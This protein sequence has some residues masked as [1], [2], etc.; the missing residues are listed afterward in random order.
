MK[1]QYSLALW[2]WAALWLMHIW[3]IKHIEEKWIIVNEVSWTSMWAIIAWLYAMWFD[4]NFMYNF[5]NQINFLKLIDFDLKNWLLKWDKIFKKLYEVFWD[6]LIEKQKIKLVIVSTNI[7]T[8]EK[9]VFKKWKIIDAVIASI[10]LPGI[11]KPYKIDNKLLID[12]WIMSNLP[13]EVLDWKNVIAVS[14]IK[15]IV[16]QLQTKRNILWFDVNVWFFNLNYQ[17]IQRSLLF[18]M[19]NNEEVSIKTLWK[20]VILI[21]PDSWKLEF[22]NFNKIDELFNLGYKEAVLV[23]N[24][25]K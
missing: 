15:N 16:W 14:V 17:V 13:I 22:H 18:M 2:W 5:A 25:L 10:S 1:K 11:F 4:S 6:E 21:K 20:D 3:V 12:W 9:I 8:W 7:E 24:D 19:K 23:L